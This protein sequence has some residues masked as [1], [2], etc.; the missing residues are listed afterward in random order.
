MKDHDRFILL[1]LE[2]VD[3]IHSAAN[4]TELHSGSRS[5]LVRMTMRDLE[6]KLDPEQFVRI[7]RLTIVNVDRVAEIRPEFHGEFQVVIQD[8][9][10]LRLSRRYPRPS[11]ALS[12]P[13]REGG[14]GAG[15]SLDGLEPFAGSLSK[16]T[17]YFRTV[18]LLHLYSMPFGT[19]ATSPALNRSS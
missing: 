13:P 12:H 8:G 3:W 17:Q 15:H 19:S 2:E 1:K 9:T 11:A 5:F 7:H 16:M 6:E 4:Y 10:Q 14:W 18:S